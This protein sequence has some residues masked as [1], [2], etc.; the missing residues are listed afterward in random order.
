LRWPLRRLYLAQFRWRKAVAESAQVPVIASVRAAFDFFKQNAVR[1]APGAAVAGLAGFIFSM[2]VASGDLVLTFGAF[3]LWTLT[4]VA[5]RAAL[6]RFAFTGDAGGLSGMRLSADEGRLAVVTLLFYLF[7]GLVFLVAAAPVVLVV[8]GVVYGT[9]DVAALEA[10][11]GDQAATLQAMGPQA[12]AT[13]QF[14]AILIM[15]LLVF[16]SVRFCLYEV[17]TMAERRIVFLKSWPWTGGSFW[18]LLAAIILASLPGFIAWN[19]LSAIG[20]ALSQA[21][22]APAGALFVLASSF[23]GVWLGGMMGVGLLA[24]LYRGLRPAAADPVSS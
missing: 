21:G 1:F 20:A 14:G 24:F 5:Y 7:L 15:I 13:L 8:L 19:L 12:A 18:R 10:A 3:V 4:A 17:A 22:A 11:A 23:A 16:V 6:Y 2:A 9:A